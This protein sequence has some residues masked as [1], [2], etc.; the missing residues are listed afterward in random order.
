LGRSP[1]TPTP[2]SAPLP[3]FGGGPLS[4][5]ALPS[6]KRPR[7]GAADGAM[8]PSAFGLGDFLGGLMGA[9]GD[10]GSLRRAGEVGGDVIDPEPEADEKDAAVGGGRGDAGGPGRRAAGRRRRGGKGQPAA[11]AYGTACT[12]ASVSDDQAAA[13]ARVSRC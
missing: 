5:A 10:L 6:G 12:G 9:M 4:A 7:R 11:A 2:R 3:R 8:L 13:S 1:L